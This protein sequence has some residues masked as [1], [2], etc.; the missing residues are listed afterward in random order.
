[1]DVRRAITA[2]DFEN[3]ERSWRFLET[4]TWFGW[5]HQDA[6]DA[7]ECLGFADYREGPE[8]DEN[9]VN[10]DKY[11]IF[12]IKVKGD[13]IYIKL[14]IRYKLDNKLIIKSFHVDNLK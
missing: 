7:I 9:D 11:W 12:K 13:L 5:M 2:R 6:Y 3:H 4:L 1:M 8:D 10:G 14:K